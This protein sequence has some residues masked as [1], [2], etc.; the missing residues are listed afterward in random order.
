MSI[1]VDV[2]LLSGKCAS[3]EVEADASVE[4]LKQRAQSALVTGRGRLLNSSGE[5]LDGT[6]TIAETGLK[7][8]DVLTLHLSQVQ[9]Q[10]TR[11]STSGA[12]YVCRTLG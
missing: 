11:R 9:L 12:L 2:Y 8:G 5:V 1:S 3:M 4:S 10:G 6:K 7:G